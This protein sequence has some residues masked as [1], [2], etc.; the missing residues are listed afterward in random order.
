MT[1]LFLLLEY[2]I[3]ADGLSNGVCLSSLMNGYSVGVTKTLSNL[4]EGS[5]IERIRDPR[6]LG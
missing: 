4:K 2:S 3:Q 1:R 5:R 6:D